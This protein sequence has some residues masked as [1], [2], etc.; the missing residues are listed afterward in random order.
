MTRILIEALVFAIVLVTLVVIIATGAH[1]QG[2]DAGYMQ[3]LSDS[4]ARP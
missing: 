1:T 2:Y 4:G 3:C